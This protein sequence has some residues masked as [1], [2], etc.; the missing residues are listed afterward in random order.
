[1][2]KL[3]LIFFL[4]AF[5]LFSYGQCRS[6][7]YRI[8]MVHNNPGE[9]EYESEFNNPG[10]LAEMG[11]NGKSYFLFDSPTLAINWDDFDKRIMPQGSPLR[12]W[13][14][15]KSARLHSM[16]NACK[17]KGLEVYA[18]SDLI[19]L[20]KKLI[21]LYHIEN[22]FG[23][24]Q[25][26]LTQRILRYQIKAI[27][28]QFPQMDGLIVRI[29]E[30][31]LQD[32]PYH[33]GS[34]IGKK[35]ADN[36]IIP[37]LNLLRD[38]ICVKLNKKLFFRTWWSFD[39][40]LDK[41]LYITNM[42]QPHPNLIISVKHCEGDFHRGHSFS[43]ILG[44][45]RHQQLVEVQCS[46]EYEG[47][48]AFPNY[49]A[50]GV[51]DGFPEDDSLRQEGKPCCIRDI[52]KTGKLA[53]L[54]TWSRG[55]GWEGPY[56]K[57]ELWSEMNAWVLSAWA[58]NPG[59]SE[60]KLFRDYCR[61]HLHL[62]NNNTEMMRK[63]ALLSEDACL[64]AFNKKWNPDNE[65]MGIRDMYI[66]FPVLPANAGLA[67]KLIREQDEAVEDFRQIANLSGKIQMPDT[68]RQSAVRVSCLYGLQMF[69]IFRSLYHLAGIRQLRLPYDKALYI[70]EYDVAWK[71]VE[72]LA[73]KYPAAC[74]SL[75]SKMTVRRTES[76]V[77]DSIVNEMR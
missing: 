42:V 22:T 34:I 61:M 71:E 72:M 32:A 20:P 39:V 76:Q 9:Q 12:E 64:K 24:P 27:F 7:K 66:P 65:P 70:R 74:P 3:S 57:D 46:R 47:K 17:R 5:S 77:A 62:D 8:D 21:E 68:I 16:Y 49:I 48:G 28:Q 4:T 31:Y 6:L 19:L 44:K 73:R 2:K 23:N 52:Y 59:Y 50:R 35:D 10:I 54:W 13:A 18:M 38:E 36:C 14:E 51:I 43:R 53:G 55:G 30:T 37:L 1:M 56:P 11:Y 33:Q 29:G 60:E 41:Y 15:R 40:D 69:R 26:T 58:V 67:D 63:I 45:G 75:Y 25:D